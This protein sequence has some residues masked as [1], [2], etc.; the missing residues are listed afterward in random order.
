MKLMTV[1]RTKGCFQAI[2]AS[3]VAGSLLSSGVLRA[4]VAC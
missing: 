1:H 3:P 2:C 4:Q